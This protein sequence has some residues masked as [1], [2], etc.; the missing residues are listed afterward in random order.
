MKIGKHPLRR[1]LVAVVCLLAAPVAPL[2]GQ[3]EPAAEFGETVE[4]IEVLLDVLATD[5]RGRVITGLTADDFVI[6]EGGEVREITSATFYTNRYED[7]EPEA[8]NAPPPPQGFPPA[9]LPASRYFILFFHDQTAQASDPGLLVSMRLRAAR[10]ARSW[11]EEEMAPSDWIAVA[12]FDH[13]LTIHTD[14]TQD[15]LA[16]VE[17]I[18]T[19]TLN[20][21]S[22]VLR[23]SIR[24][25]RE[26]R[27]GPS[28]TAGLPDSWS[29]DKASLRIEDAVRLVAQASRPI[30]GR[31]NLVLFTLGF[32]QDES[33]MGT[34]DERYYPAMEAA[35]N[36]SNIAVYP[37]DLNGSGNQTPQNNF[38]SLLAD[39]TG[40][41]YFNTFNRFLDPLR[42][43]SRFNTGY[44][45]LSFRSEVPGGERGY[46]HF[47]VKAKD[48]KV[49]VRARR[50]YRFGPREPQG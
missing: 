11:V 21:R 45:L 41:I 22:S 1:H 34:P 6:E 47:R 40:G 42:D 25:R 16:I 9:H 33:P 17:A 27:P 32:G 35:L 14:F 4:V 24:S 2:A 38:L 37:I 8:A 44:Y 31:K 28:L 19:A 5:R 29:L 10:D 36:D 12:R 13:G 30:I 48:R 3:E 26:A 46:R 43:I 20:K 18:D 15:R 39:E 23:P 7:L 50:G 49:K